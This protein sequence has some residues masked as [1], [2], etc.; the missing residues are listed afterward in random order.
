MEVYLDGAMAARLDPSERTEFKISTGKHIL[1]VNRGCLGDQTAAIEITADKGE[2]KK[3]RLVTQ[4][5]SLSIQPT[6]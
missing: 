1:Q 3:Y 6:M 5:E 2:T 4:Q